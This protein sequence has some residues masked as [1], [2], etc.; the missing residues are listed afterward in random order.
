MHG[1]MVGQARQ[2]DELTPKPEP[3]VVPMHPEDKTHLR[4]QADDVILLEDSTH[5]SSWGDDIKN[6]KQGNSD[7]V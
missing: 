4:L 2:A 3:A 7:D 1:S 5:L 6:K